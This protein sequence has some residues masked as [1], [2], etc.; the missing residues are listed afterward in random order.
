MSVFRAADF[1]LEFYFDQT[2]LLYVLLFLQPL[3][4]GIAVRLTAQL[5][6]CFFAAPWCSGTEAVA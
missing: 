5:V 4:R 6:P 2:R 1:D 3:Y